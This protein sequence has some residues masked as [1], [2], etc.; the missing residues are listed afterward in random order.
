MPTTLRPG[1]RVGYRARFVRAVQLEPAIELEEAI[2]DTYR[3]GRE[4]APMPPAIPGCGRRL[5]P[6]DRRG[7]VVAVIDHPR[8]PRVTIQWDDT[9]ETN[10]ALT[11][12][13]ARLDSAA[14]RD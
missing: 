13:V 4:H 9:G 7:T 10:N 5:K 1:D 11:S 6:E 8:V 12:N 3:A 14:W 2:S